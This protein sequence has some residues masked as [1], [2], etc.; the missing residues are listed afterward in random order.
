MTGLDASK[1]SIIQIFCFVT[2]YD[3]NLLDREGWG[4]IIY[5]S[6]PVLDAMD[7]WCTRTHA[8]TGLT[9]AALASTVTPEE[10]AAGL[11]RYIQTHV[12]E[13]SKAVLAGNTVHA[14]RA[15]LSK[16]PYDKVLAHLHYRIFDVSTI[17]EAV[18]RWGSD[19]MLQQVPRK[20]G[21]HEARQDILESIEEAKYYR[22]VLFPN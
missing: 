7:E 13:A 2:D 19:K 10:A 20:K 4:T 5:H 14:D 8:S 11:L 6:K 22:K 21:L 15:F 9:A 12:P 16:P 1:H 3:L 18:R 17:K